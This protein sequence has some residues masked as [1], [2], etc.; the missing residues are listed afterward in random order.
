M[1]KFF[2]VFQVA[3]LF[4]LAFVVLL[5]TPALTVANFTQ[6]KSAARQ[7]LADFDKFVARLIESYRVRTAPWSQVFQSTVALNQGFGVVGEIVF[8]GPLRAA[9]GVIKGA[10]A[11]LNVVGCAFTIDPAD[12]QYTAGGT[13]VF[14]GILANPKALS[15]VGTAAGGPLAPTLTVPNGTVGEFV[16]LGMLV[17]A[18]AN[19]AKIGDKVMFAKATGVLSAIPPVIAYSGVIAVTTGILTVSASSAGAN[20]Y[21]GMPVVG[22]GV[23][24]GTIIRAL[25][26]GTGG[27]GTY[28]T[29]I[30]TAVSAFTDGKAV[31]VAPA[32]STIIESGEVVRFTNAAAGLA[33]V[34]LTDA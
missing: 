9:P 12:G 7:I 24:A 29:N 13:G 2:H 22:T 33:V 10:D 17:V 6:A 31:N 3:A 27:D 20:I 8:E 5:V 18:L 21:V 30:V 19:A 32:G 11:T 16:S 26:T 14:G 4:A 28:Q 15:S 23:P 1:K 34:S 25:G